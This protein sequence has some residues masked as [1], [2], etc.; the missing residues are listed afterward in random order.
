MEI[1]DSFLLGLIQGLTEFLP[2]SSSGD[3]ILGEAMLGG[4]L[5]KNIVFQVVVRIEALSSI[6]LFYYKDILASLRDLLINRN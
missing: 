3:F 2:T 1:I 5:D 4:K 6:L